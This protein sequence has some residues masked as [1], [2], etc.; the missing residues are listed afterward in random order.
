MLALAATAPAVQAQDANSQGR[1]EV[2]LPATL[3]ALEGLD[4]GPIVVS[5][6]GGAMTINPSTNASSTVGAIV[7]VG[8]TSHR[9]TF[10]SQLPVGLIIFYLG[11]PSVT[12]TRQGGTETMTAS[13]TYA[14]GA[15]LGPGPFLGTRISTATDQ[16]YYAGGT[17][18]VSAGQVPGLYE[19]TFN[20]AIDNL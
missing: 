14:T 1:A 8:T 7:R 3:T 2:V 6:A 16:Y 9:A 12:L 13:L 5:G 11:D 17:L 18:F 4:F 19:G 20:L 10:R 15:G